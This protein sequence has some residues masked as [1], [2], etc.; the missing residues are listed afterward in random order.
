[1]S[2]TAGLSVLRPADAAQAQALKL[3][4]PLG[5][6][7][8]GGGTALQ[9]AWASGVPTL[10]L[11][12]VDALPAAQGI[13]AVDEAGSR[14]LRIG[15][16]YKLEALRRD[17]LLREVAPLLAAACDQIGAPSVRHL[18][19]LGGNVG[20]RWGDTLAPLLAMDAQAELAG[21]QR[22]PL[23]PL[24]AAPELPLLVA[25]WLPRH[26][27]PAGLAVYEKVAQR[28]AFAPSRLALALWQ[29]HGRPLQIAATGAGWVARRLGGAEAWCQAAARTPADVETD[30]PREAPADAL[31][32]VMAAARATTP[33]ASAALQAACTA[34]LDGH[35]AL[36]RLAAR[37]A[38][39]HLRWASSGAGR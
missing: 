14:W 11:L 28:A 22:V 19:T 13:S 29:V 5:T 23:A 24:L 30:A 4:D 12:A 15:A 8:V 2:A 17:P 18:A 20:W 3:A 33:A 1:M 36:G 26:D 37:L 27:V 32:D 34:D 39:G 21:G 38:L 31:D 7:Y 10:R 6:T 16:A 35:T 9:L 25:L